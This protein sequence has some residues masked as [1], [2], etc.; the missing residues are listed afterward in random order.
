MREK[1]FVAR[2]AMAF[3][4]RSDRLR[5]VPVLELDEYHAVVLALPEKPKPAIVMHDS[6]DSFSFSSK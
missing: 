6:T 5:S 2:S 3:A 1:A 4:L